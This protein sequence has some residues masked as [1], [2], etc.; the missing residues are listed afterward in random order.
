M[1]VG[2]SGFRREL[3]TLSRIKNCVNR[4]RNPD[5]RFGHS[6]SS[7]MPQLDVSIPFRKS[8]MIVKEQSMA[9]SDSREYAVALKVIR[10]GVLLPLFVV[11]L[12]DMV[13]RVEAVEQDETA[14]SKPAV[15]F[16][17]WHHVDTDIR[18]VST[19]C[20]RERVAQKV[21]EGLEYYPGSVRTRIE[22][23]QAGVWSAH[24][25]REGPQE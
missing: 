2:S 9:P 8:Q 21:G 24:R 17:D 25:R 16:V 11:V 10:M 12:T 19:L 3:T 18:P 15:L 1:S 22:T 20:R 4:C 7:V 14:N 6:T 5:A 13:F 23:C